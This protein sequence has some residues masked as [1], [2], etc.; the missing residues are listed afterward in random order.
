[1]KY[2]VFNCGNVYNVALLKPNEQDVN[3]AHNWLGAG[4]HDDAYGGRLTFR[5]KREFKRFLIIKSLF[6]DGIDAVVNRATMRESI[7]R[8][9]HIIETEVRHHDFMTNLS[10][11][12]P[13]Y[14]T[15]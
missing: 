12:M 10:T 1:M 2:L 4:F 8:A 9:Q 3:L 11:P 6:R 14:E 7:K 15:R 5:S 13:V